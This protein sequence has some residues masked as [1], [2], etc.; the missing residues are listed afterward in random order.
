MKNH[1][2]VLM[3]QVSIITG[4]WVQMMDMNLLEPGKTPHE[5]AQFLVFLCAVIKA[6][7]E[8][9]DLLKSISCKPWK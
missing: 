6:V 7:D 5:N 8:Y 3:V 1:L 9:A 2:Q 4:Q